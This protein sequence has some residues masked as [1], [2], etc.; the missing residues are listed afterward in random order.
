MWDSNDYK[1]KCQIQLLWDSIG[2]RIIA[3]RSNWL[4]SRSIWDPMGL[5]FKSWSFEAQEQSFS[6]RLPSKMKLWSSKTKLF[7]ETSSKN[8]D[9]KLKNE[10]F[11][12]D[13]LQKWS[14][15][16][17][18]G[19]VFARLPSKMKLWTQKRS[20]STRPPSTMKLWNS[21]RKCFCATSFKNQA[22]KIKKEACLQDFLQ[23]M[24]LWSSKTKLFCKTSFKH[25]A[26]KLKNEAFLRDFLQKRHVDQT[27]DFR[28]YNTFQRFLRRCFKS[29]APATR[30]LSRGIRSP[31]TATRNDP[32]KGTLAW[33]EIR[34]PSTDSTSET[35]NIDMTD[36]TIPALATRKASFRTL[37]KSTTPANVFATLKKSKSLRLP[38][39]KHFQFPKTPRDRQFLTIL[40]FKS[41]SRHSVA[42]ILRSSASKS[43]PNPR[44]FNDFGLEIALARRHGANFAK[45]NFKKCSEPPKLYRFWLRN[46][47]RA[48][49]WCKFCGAQLPKVL[50]THGALTILAWKS[51]SRAGMAQILRR[52]T[53]KSAPN[54]PSFIDFDF[55]TALAPQ[56]G[57]N[58]AKLSFQKCSEP[59]VF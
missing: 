17:Q 41:L 50:R 52:P 39:E 58:F 23:K 48:T 14:F 55:E 22:W 2:L 15:E 11:L 40:T 29:I 56:R 53:S 5:K 20:F 42:Q 13:L 32:C 31:A 49:A 26:L 1:F 43:A 51:L 37:F 3:L 45:A 6:A 38:R 21:E 10:A 4:A 19:N 25:E 35:S 34:N 54:P 18:K 27:L 24:N 16:T 59:T 12:R 9:L 36:R 33:H 57:A 46:R 47:S 44:C 30:K 8:E 7:C 28:I